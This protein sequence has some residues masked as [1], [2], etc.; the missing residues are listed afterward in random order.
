[1]NNKEDRI[2]IGIAS[3]VAGSFGFDWKK[4]VDIAY[5]LEVSV[6]QLHLNQFN[7][8]FYRQ[9]NLEG[10]FNQ[11]YM[12]LPAGFIHSHPLINSFQ[13]TSNTPLL[14]Q[15]QCYLNEDDINFFFEHRLPLG[16]ENDQQDNL[17]TYFN[18][19]KKLVSAGLNFSGVIDLPRFYHQFYHK[20][21]EV[22]IFNHILK[23]LLW[24]KTSKIPVIIHAIDI[25]DYQRDR[26][27]WVP[28]FKGILP[29]KKILTFLIEESIPV[30][31][32]IF[33]YED[34]PNTEKSVYFLREWF[35]KY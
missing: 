16:F 20:H 22:D 35:K 14:I 15:H 6:I 29:W 1:L 10:R 32:I 9:I 30:R 12:H 7:S 25:A 3:S 21:K 19:L 17:N 33:E 27:N 24:C 34:V 18:Q 11:V 26:D 28:I 5:K 4:T 23:I 2:P 31:S 13:N 8:T